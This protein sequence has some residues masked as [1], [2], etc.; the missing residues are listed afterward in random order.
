M[1]RPVS[2]FL[3]LWLLCAIASVRAVAAPSE[4][5]ITGTT[6]GWEVCPQQFP[7]C[8]GMA[9]F[10][11]KFAGQV[12]NKQNASGAFLVGV[13]HVLPLNTTTNGATTPI[14]GGLWQIVTKQG[15]QE[16]TGTIMPGTLTYDLETNSF[17]VVL[18][19]AISP[20][21]IGLVNF[22]GTLFHDPFPPEVIG[23]LSQVP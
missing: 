5:V 23:T 1:S 21:G 19:L 6:S 3:S 11:G 15:H 14:L 7:F 10:G 22:Q 20:P 4:P 17:T 18:Q 12:G 2:V 9:W 8:G 16:I 13:Q